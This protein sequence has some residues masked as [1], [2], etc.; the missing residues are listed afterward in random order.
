METKLIKKT[1]LASILLLAMTN[2]CAQQ[3]QE[4]T[5]IPVESIYLENKGNLLALSSITSK[6]IR[7]FLEKPTNIVIYN[8]EWSDEYD[9]Q[10]TYEYELCTI[11]FK[12]FEDEEWLDYIESLSSDIFVIINGV[13][14]FAGVQD[15][16]LNVFENSWKIYQDLEN[17]KEYL[18]RVERGDVEKTFIMKFPIKKGDYEYFGLIFIGVEGNSIVRITLFLQDEP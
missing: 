6:S 11:I 12:S 9:K 17:T 16:V 15:S 3:K 18:N 14:L 13:R 5:V 4:F 1:M 8:E 2:A 10:I 7:G